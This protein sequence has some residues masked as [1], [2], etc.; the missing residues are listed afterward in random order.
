MPVSPDTKGPQCYFPVLMQIKLSDMLSPCLKASRGFGDVG[1]PHRVS[2]LHFDFVWGC[3]LS[4][5]GA[6]QPFRLLLHLHPM[7]I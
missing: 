3:V 6:S 5:L 4:P 2:V 1:Q 7:D